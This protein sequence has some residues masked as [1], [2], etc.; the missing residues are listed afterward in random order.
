MLYDGAIS[1][2]FIVIGILNYADS[3]ASFYYNTIRFLFSI[4]PIER[5]LQSQ[6]RSF[7][8]KQIYLFFFE[9]LSDTNDDIALSVAC[10]EG[11]REMDRGEESKHPQQIGAEIV[12]CY[13]DSQRG[14]A[15]VR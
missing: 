5:V 9:G 8:C 10:R 15:G 7:I 1:S 6:H 3:L 11:R 14:E 12:R 13:A 2:A 4:A